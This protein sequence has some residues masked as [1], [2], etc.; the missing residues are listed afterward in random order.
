VHHEGLPGVSD[1][2]RKRELEALQRRTREALKAGLDAV[3]VHPRDESGS[4]AS[5]RV[6]EWH[7]RLGLPDEPKFLR[8]EE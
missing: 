1:E 2:E 7:R 6:R 4:P 8:D 5:E 3:N